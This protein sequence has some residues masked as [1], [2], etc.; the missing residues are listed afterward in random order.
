VRIS[1][2]ASQGRDLDAPASTLVE[3]MLDRIFVNG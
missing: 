2:F 1:E 3:T